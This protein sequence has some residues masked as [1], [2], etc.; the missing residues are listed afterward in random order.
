MG[1]IAYFAESSTD[2]LQTPTAYAN[3]K[4][5]VMKPVTARANSRFSQR[6]TTWVLFVW[7]R[8]ETFLAKIKGDIRLTFQFKSL[9]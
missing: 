3:I 8:I 7:A 9:T 5:N 1:A 2:M 4:R 6:I